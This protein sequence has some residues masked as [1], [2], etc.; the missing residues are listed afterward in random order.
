VASDG[1]WAINIPNSGCTGNKLFAN[2]LY[3]HHSYR[4]AIN[5]VDGARTGF[6]SNFNVLEGIFSTNDGDSILTFNQWKSLGY[7]AN[8]KVA[9][10]AQ[11]FVNPA[12]DFHLRS[13]SPAIN[14]GQVLTSVKHDFAGVARPDGPS[15][16]AGA[17]EYVGLAPDADC[18]LSPTSG[19]VYT[20]ITVSCTDFKSGEIISVRWDGVVFA[21]FTAGS[22]GAGSVRITAPR[23]LTGR[24]LIK[25]IG[26]M[27]TS[28]PSRG[29]RIQPSISLSPTGGTVDQQINVVLRGF[30]A[31]EVIRL[32]FRTA[33]GSSRTVA[34]GIVAS[35]TGTASATFQVP[36]G[37]V[38]QFSIE[39]SGSV[40]GFASAPFTRI[41]GTAEEPTETPTPSPA[42]TPDLSPT[43]THTPEPTVTA[44]PSIPDPSATTAPTEV[45]ETP[46]ASPIEPQPLASPTEPTTISPPTG[47]PTGETPTVSPV[48]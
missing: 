20:R 1:R 28:V 45:T 31:G 13:A 48:E 16:D 10:P 15:S 25:A 22:S 37:A 44:T 12:G 41:L 18:A 30:G 42:A 3:S 21:S 9:T 26:D 19:V 5:V 17:Y 43:A 33:P 24:H 47:V 14:I 38:G 2:I 29:F 23:S 6:E 36:S 11:I 32:R 27:G 35:S 46:T 7:D 39:A 8:S 40:G 4:G 34:S